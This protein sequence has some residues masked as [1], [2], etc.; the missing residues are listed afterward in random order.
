MTDFIEAV[1]AE[2]LRAWERMQPLLARLEAARAAGEDPA[3]VIDV[4]YLLARMYAE[5]RLFID[6]RL[7]ERLRLCPASARSAR[8]YLWENYGDEAGS[9]VPGRDHVAL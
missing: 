5:T 8:R 7:P 4:P 1:Q 9:F 3:A 6:V 2:L